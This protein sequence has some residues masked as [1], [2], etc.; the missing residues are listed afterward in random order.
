MIPEESR[1]RYRKRIELTSSHGLESLS[2]EKWRMCRCPSVQ[3]PT[4]VTYVA[5]N[6]YHV[7]GRALAGMGNIEA[8][9]EYL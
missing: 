1:Q 7:I 2:V 8:D 9:T 4:L 5:L 6:L 3:L